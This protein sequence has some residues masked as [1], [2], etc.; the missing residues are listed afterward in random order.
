MAVSRDGSTLLVADAAGGSDAIHVYNIADGLRRRVVGGA[1]DGPLQFSSPLQVWVAADDF[2]FVADAGNRR[3]QVLTPDLA[4]YGFVGAGQLGNPT[5]VC[6]NSDAVVAVEFYQRRISVFNRHDGA[7][8]RRFG[9]F[10]DGDDQ[11]SIPR[12]VCFL[13]DDSHIAVADSGNARVSVFSLDGEFVR[14]VGKG[15]LKFAHSVACSAFDELVVADGN[16]I[17]L[18][19]ASGHLVRT[20]G[21][22]LRRD[23]RSPDDSCIYTEVKGVAIHGGSIFA[24]DRIKRRHPTGMDDGGFFSDSKCVRFT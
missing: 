10:G 2:V 11:L 18:F 19:N 22:G 6:A 21:E 7:L 20:L 4:F 17:R 23:V 1:G 24:A 14:H 3:I 8:L 15:I 9:S 5:G 16:C 13:F 12:A